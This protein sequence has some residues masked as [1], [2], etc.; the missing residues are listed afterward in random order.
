MQVIEL[1]ESTARGLDV[2]AGATRAL[3]SIEGKVRWRDDGVAPT[4][5]Q[6]HPMADERVV[7]SGPFSA[8]KFIAQAGPDAVVTASFYR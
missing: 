4:A 3:I 5:T 7:F 2:P 6:G 8:L 1:N